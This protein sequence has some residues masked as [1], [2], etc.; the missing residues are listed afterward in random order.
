MHDVIQWMISSSLNH[1]INSYSWIW[2]A[3]ESL[4]FIGLCMLVGSLLV[5]DL[6]IIGFN[7]GTFFGSIKNF[8]FVTLIGFTINLITGIAFLFG[9]PNRY[10]FNP[11]FQLK[12]LLIFL[13]IVNALYLS[14]RMHKIKLVGQMYQS[15][16]TPIDIKIVAGF[17][18]ILWACVIVL[19]RFI[20]YVE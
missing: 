14:F 3:L 18:L 15:T 8:I 4:H 1:F 19:G 6:K 12:M 2:P 13:A 5:V 9:D 7:K 10:F 20:P 17:S 16:S 11:S